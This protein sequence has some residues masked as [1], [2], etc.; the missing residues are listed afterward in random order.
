MRFLKII[1]LKVYALGFCL[2]TIMYNS[3]MSVYY[4]ML[5]I[6]H[7]SRTDICVENE[8]CDKTDALSRC[9]VVASR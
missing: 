7:E 1:A 6:L 8:R 2:V 3:N 4:L 9:R 5:L